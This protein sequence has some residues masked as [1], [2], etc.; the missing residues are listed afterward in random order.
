MAAA[1]A[2]FAQTY[3]ENVKNPA[4]QRGETHFATSLGRKPS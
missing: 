2:S 4:S 3:P 1:S